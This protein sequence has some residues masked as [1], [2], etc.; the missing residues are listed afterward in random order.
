M[1][2]EMLG[3][4]THD[5]THSSTKAARLLSLNHLRL[6]PRDFVMLCTVQKSYLGMAWL[7]A[8]EFHKMENN[9]HGSESLLNMISI[10]VAQFLLS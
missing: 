9:K 3:M 6:C 7:Y 10:I 4:H 8:Q 2:Y 5:H 1:K